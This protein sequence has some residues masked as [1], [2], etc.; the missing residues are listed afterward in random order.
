AVNPHSSHVNVTRVNGITTVQ[1][2]PSGG[3]I[4]GQ[5]AVINL[6]GSTQGD[7]AVVPAEGLVIN[8]PRIATFGGF[9]PGAGPQVVDFNEAVKRRDT[10][11]H[12]RSEEHP[13][14]LQSHSELV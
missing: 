10:Q 4:A 5:S 1:T 12:E 2:S 11:I 14:E 13:S 8:F 3:L 6:N 7:I 9:N